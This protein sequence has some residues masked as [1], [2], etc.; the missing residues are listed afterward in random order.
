MSPGTEAKPLS[1]GQIALKNG[2][3]TKEQIHQCIAEQKAMQAKGQ[4]PPRLGELMITKGFL[5]EAQ[6]RTIFRLQ[7]REG[8]HKEVAGYKL[9]QK[10]GE[11]GMGAV[12]RATQVSMDRTVA[13]KILAPRLAKNDAFV[14]RFLREARAVARLS[15]VNIIAGIDVGESNGL[16]YFAMEYVDGPT[17]RDVLGRGAMDEG[18]AVEIALQIAR[19]LDHAAK[20]QL[21]H[22]DI[23]PDNVMLDR[24]GQAKLCDL[25]LAKS[26]DGEQKDTASQTGEG[27]A[28][29]TPNYMAPE[30]A[31]ADKDIDTR[32]DIYSLGATLYHMVTGE[33]PFVGPAAVVVTRHLTEDPVPPHLRKPGVSRGISAVIT[34]CM[35]KDRDDRYRWAEELAKDLERLQRGEWPIGTGPPPAGVSA[36]APVAP[37]GVAQALPA[38]QVDAGEGGKM[39][40][41]NSRQLRRRRR[42]RRR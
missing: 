20:N 10:I 22:R 1:F 4:A 26:I 23:K 27:S 36:A 25:G 3:V 18:R 15:H 33:T 5:T 29:G 39:I 34:K 13:L 42:R 32:A 31:R 24:G 28:A 37:G 41:M 30:I 35:E 6:V 11:G 21:I 14:A 12:F 38:E 16:Y 17:L 19:A 2:L 7:G 9:H 40:Q 8:G